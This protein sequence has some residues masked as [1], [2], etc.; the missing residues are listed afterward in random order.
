MEAR[1]R[2]HTHTHTHTSPP[3][4]K[5]THIKHAYTHAYTH[6]HTYRYLHMRSHIH[7]LES[8]YLKQFVY[9]IC[10]PYP[11]LSRPLGTD[12]QLNVRDK[13]LA[14]N[15]LQTHVWKRVYELL[16]SLSIKHIQRPMLITGACVC[17]H[18]CVQPIFFQRVCACIYVCVYDA[19]RY[20][21]R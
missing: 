7:T 21:E 18:A 1:A 17:V 11:A 2:A 3:T 13:M 19:N 16:S 12:V 10:Y 5:H 9:I 14:W 6:T 15:R 4:H 8:L 20:T